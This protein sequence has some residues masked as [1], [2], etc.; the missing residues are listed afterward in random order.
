LRS[1]FDIFDGP[2]GMSCPR[3][4]TSLKSF[5]GQKSCQRLFNL[6]SQRRASLEKNCLWRLWRLGQD[7]KDAKDE[8]VVLLMYTPLFILAPTDMRSSAGTGMQI[9][10]LQASY[11]GRGHAHGRQRPSR[12]HPQST[13]PRVRLPQARSW[14]SFDAESW[15]RSMRTICGSILMVVDKNKKI[16]K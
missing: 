15:R 2:G 12:I 1:I 7:V 5:P 3:H 8:H 11:V 16:K 6:P 10:S 9:P 4:L 14:H 13:H